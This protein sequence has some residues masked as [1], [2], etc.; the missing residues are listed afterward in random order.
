MISWFGGRFVYNC[1]GLRDIDEMD[2]ILVR[3]RWLGL[4]ECRFEFRW[5]KKKHYAV[6]VK[7]FSVVWL[8]DVDSS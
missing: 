5:D 3:A 2:I 7:I 6:A 1:V 8:I 4:A